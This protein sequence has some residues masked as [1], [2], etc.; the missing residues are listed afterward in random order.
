MYITWG[1]FFSFILYTYHIICQEQIWVSFFH[2][3]TEFNLT[4]TC[5]FHIRTFFIEWLQTFISISTIYEAMVE[6][7]F[8]FGISALCEA[9]VKFRF[10]FGISVVCKAMVKFR[11]SFRISTL[12]EAMVEF[13]FSFGTSRP[14]M[15]QW[16]SVSLNQGPLQDNGHCFLM[17]HRDPLHG[18]GHWVPL[19]RM[20]TLSLDVVMSIFKYVWLFFTYFIFRLYFFLKPEWN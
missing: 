19:F 1:N 6:F 5:K 10:S 11:F 8:S 4:I 18:N 2:A 7:R 16:S 9:M 14:S 17:L 3:F 20:E 15:R 13:R 12:C